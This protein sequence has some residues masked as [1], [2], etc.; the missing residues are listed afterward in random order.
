MQWNDGS[1]IGQIITS[2]AKKFSTNCQNHVTQNF[3]KWLKK[4]LSHKVEKHITEDLCPKKE[5][6]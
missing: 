4:W 5:I 1:Y 2:L 6:S 3:D